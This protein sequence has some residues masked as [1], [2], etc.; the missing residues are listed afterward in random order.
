MEN[1]VLGHKSPLFG[2]RTAQIKLEG[3][4]YIEASKFLKGYGNEDKIKFY[5]CIGGTPYYLSQIDQG[6][7]FKKISNGCFSIF[8]VTCTMNLQCCCSR[9]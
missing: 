2:R 4:N 7:S 5:S 6:M 1:E 8:P 9:N 3:F